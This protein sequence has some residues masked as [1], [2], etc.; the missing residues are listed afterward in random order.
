M[1][2]I[3]VRID[4]ELAEMV[5]KSLKTD[6]YTSL[7][8]LINELLKHYAVTHSRLFVQM[9]PAVVESICKE[10]LDEI[11][12][13]NRIIFR[14]NERNSETIMKKLSEIYALFLPDIS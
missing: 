13:E 9:L 7:N 3:T 1:K 4:D 11:Q 2:R 12:K 8:Q 14:T 5:E 10:H 6:G